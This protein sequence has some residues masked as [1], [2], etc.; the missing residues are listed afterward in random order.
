MKTQKTSAFALGKMLHL[1]GLAFF[2]LLFYMAFHSKY[3]LNKSPNI[4]AYTRNTPMMF[5]KTDMKL[6][7]TGLSSTNL[8]ID[9]AIFFSPV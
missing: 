5:R 4:A 7:T 2:F 9:W 1:F 6:A 3:V 8:P